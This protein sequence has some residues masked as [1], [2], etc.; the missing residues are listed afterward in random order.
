MNNF[1]QDVLSI[2]STVET[3]IGIMG[4]SFNPPHSGHVY[5]SNLAIKKLNLNFLLWLITPQNPLKDKSNLLDL[6]DRYKLCKKLTNNNYKIKI[7]TLEKDLNSKYTFFTIQQLITTLPKHIKLIWIMGEDILYS[8]DKFYR[9]KDLTK[10]I[11]IAIISRGGNNSFFSLRQ[12]FSQIMEK[13]YINN[14][15]QLTE[16]PSPSWGFF[17]LPKLTISSTIIRGKNN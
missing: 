15:E 9:W 6:S 4:G 2:K 17:L 10:L 3:T 5:I 13:H 16:L 14:F 11:N 1:W 8:F 12:K 7:S